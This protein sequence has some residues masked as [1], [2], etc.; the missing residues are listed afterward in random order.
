MSPHTRR[1]LLRAAG[2]ATAAGL[3]GCGSDSSGTTTPTTT[4]YGVVV[5]NRM[6]P[7]DF[8]ESMWL[9]EQTPAVVEVTVRDIDPDTD[10]TFLDETFEVPVGESKTVQ[11]AFTTRPDGTM[12]AMTAKAEPFTDEDRPNTDDLEASLTFTP[13]D[14][15]QPEADPIPVVVTTTNRGEAMKM[16]PAVDI[17]K[18]TGE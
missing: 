6:R 4:T 16:L 3:A 8:E 13:A 9:H 15:N 1:A 12:Y 17:R 11:E 5:D 18:T 14:G 7:S 10:R 2:I